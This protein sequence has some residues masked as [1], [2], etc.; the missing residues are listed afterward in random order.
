M[1][2]AK[3]YDRPS[4][5]LLRILELRRG[6]G[7]A[8][9]GTCSRDTP[10]VWCT[11]FAAMPSRSSLSL[12]VGAGLATGSRDCNKPFRTQRSALRRRRSGTFCGIS[13]QSNGWHG[14]T[15][16]RQNSSQS[17]LRLAMSC[18]RFLGAV[19]LVGEAVQETTSAESTFVRHQV[20]RELGGP[21]CR[22]WNPTS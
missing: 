12:T 1:A 2:F 14:Q 4:T 21:S 11:S 5:R 19:G 3:S 9:D 15:D 22:G 7:A 6:T 8:L 20:A 16:G 13:E 17:G 18:L 10:S